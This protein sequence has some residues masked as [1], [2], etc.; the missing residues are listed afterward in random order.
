MDG[1]RAYLE[2]V[3]HGEKYTDPGPVGPRPAIIALI[4]HAQT[5]GALTMS[6]AW[7]LASSEARRLE[8]AIGYSPEGG[9]GALVVLAAASGYL[10]ARE[11]GFVA[12]MGPEE[13]EPNEADVQRRLVEGLSRW[14]APPQT[15]AGLL[16]ALGLHPMWGLRV[17]HEVRS[18]AHPESPCLKDMRIFPLHNMGVVEN[19]IFGTLGT[20]FKVLNSLHPTKSYPV[21]AF[22]QVI[23]VAIT[24]QRE[25]HESFVEDI[26][27]SLP[28]FTNPDSKGNCVDFAQQDFFRAVLVPA[29]IVRLLPN[30]RFVVNADVLEGLLVGMLSDDDQESCFTWFTAHLEES[31]VA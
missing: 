14:L 6:S 23:S 20:L 25:L 4:E 11:E 27:G 13:V 19:L 22:A 3:E 29:G 28:V 18:R 21:D 5:K 15:M 30:D 12:K 8:E 31:L 7:R 26:Q 17:A 2:L 1:L 9:W 16:V 10:A 24:S